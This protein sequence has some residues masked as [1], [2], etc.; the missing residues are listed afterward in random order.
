MN[1]RGKR[2]NEPITTAFRTNPALPDY[3]GPLW[4]EVSPDGKTI[5]YTY[6]WTA[7]R[8]DP[9]CNCFLTTPSLNTAY[10]SAS[11]L[12]DDP[13]ASYGNATMYAHASWI[14]SRRTLLTTPEL[15]DFGGGVLD[16]VAVDTLGGG[17]DSYQRWF[18]QCT[19]CGDIQTLQLYPLDEGEM[20]R[21]RDK[22]VFTSGELGTKTPD[23]RLAIYQLSVEPPS[24][25]FADPCFTHGDFNSPTWSPDGKSLAWADKRG[26][27]VGK[28]GDRLFGTFEPEGE[29]VRYGLTTNLR[30]FNP[31]Q[32]AFHEYV[33]LSRD[34]RAA[35][36]WRTRWNVLLRGP[37]YRPPT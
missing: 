2:L 1:R 5:A 17:Q 15:Y 22:L 36:G 21:Q 19:G 27:W 12:T 28:V 26:V 35:R 18:S 31:V 33:A 16:T 9:G 10:T 14:D 30:T 24:T 37:G 6:S 29:R 4:P 20:T 7:S 25:A 11:R 13:V 34:L 8:F 23:S 3:K 32:V